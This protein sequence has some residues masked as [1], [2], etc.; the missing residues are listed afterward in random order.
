MELYKRM[1][2]EQ[3]TYDALKIL[4]DDQVLFDHV[5]GEWT[6]LIEMGRRKKFGQGRIVAVKP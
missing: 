4:G 3:L 2:T 6:Y 1:I 5:V